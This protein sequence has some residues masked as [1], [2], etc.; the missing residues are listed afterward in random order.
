ME[1]QEGIPIAIDPENQGITEAIRPA[2]EG[3]SLRVPLHVL[4]HSFGNSGVSSAH[5]LGISGL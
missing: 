5:R 1:Q 4:G 3:D 2:I